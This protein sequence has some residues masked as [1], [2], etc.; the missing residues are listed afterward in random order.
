MKHRYT[1]QQVQ[2]AV[3]NSISYR[4]VLTQLGIIPAGGNY[5]VLKKFI[6]THNINT[7]HF[8][9]QGWNRNQKP[10]SKVP[11]DQY[12]SNQRSITSHKLRKRLLK[13]G[14]FLHKCSSCNLTEWLG[15]PI[16]LELDHIDGCNTNNSLQNLR[17]LCPNC[18]SKTPTF[19]R[20]KG[21]LK[22]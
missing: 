14:I 1:F 15:D 2:D 4:Q 16:P 3:S 13:D 11:I 20:S 8:K 9:G 18:H 7:D 6:A 19:R 17:L 22:I 12:L 5:A 10:I 21:S